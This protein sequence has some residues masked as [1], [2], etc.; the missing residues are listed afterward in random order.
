MQKERVQYPLIL[1]EQAWSRKNLFSKAFWEIFLAGQ[2]GWSQAGKTECH[3]GRTANHSARN[4][5]ILSDHGAIA[6]SGCGLLTNSEIKM[7]RY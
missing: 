6:I 3:L 2:N 1:M 4:W 7:A 5:F